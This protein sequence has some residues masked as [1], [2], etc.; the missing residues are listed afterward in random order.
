MR[1]KS[2]LISIVVPTY[3]EEKY[4][5]KCLK[6][7]LNQSYDN[8]EILIADGMS[9]DNTRK[10][11]TNLQKKHK[12]IILLDNKEKFQAQGR[13]L[14]IRKSKGDFIAYIDA[15][16]Y[17]S[18]NWVRTLYD[19]F[20]K[21]KV[22]DIKIIGIGSIHKDA[23]KTNFSNSITLAFNSFIGGGN[24]SYKESKKIKKVDTAYA[25]LYDK[26]LL[27]KTGLY[28]PKFLKGQ[29]LELNLRITKKLGYNLYVNPNAITYYYK[30][31]SYKKFFWQMYRYGFWRYKVSKHVGH[32]NLFSFA[33]LFFFIG[34]FF[35]SILG[36]FVNEIYFT[37]HLIYFISLLLVSVYYSIKEKANYLILILIFFLIH[38]GYG[39]GMFVSFFKNDDR[40][41]DR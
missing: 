8:I 20:V 14:A 29:D 39:L 40:R 18:K 36:F 15:H 2:P 13:N 6:S 19:S 4:I 16:S 28:N 17:A 26:K 25:C 31:E 35:F 38:F 5:E 22:E 41:R 32:Y 21:L 33:P 11:I 37:Y 1:K 34:L 30:R 24:S 9:V 7:L 3:N 12:N 27:L 23:A 10:I